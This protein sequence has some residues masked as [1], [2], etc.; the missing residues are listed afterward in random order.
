MTIQSAKVA[1]RLSLLLDR[2]G[3]GNIE[4]GT[5]ISEAA[6]DGM[7]MLEWDEDVFSRMTPRAQARATAI[8]ETPVAQ[9]LEQL[10][11]RLVE[12][13]GKIENV[14][15]LAKLS[16]TIAALLA[17]FEGLMTALIFTGVGVVV[18]GVPFLVLLALR[19]HTR[20]QIAA[21]HDEAAALSREARR[22]VEQTF[23][24][25]AIG[26][27]PSPPSPRGRPGVMTFA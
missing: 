12:R 2:N 5:E 25:R 11:E 18:L 15:D 7:R 20:S 26:Q 23:A 17:I 27:V 10:G 9:R 22:L 4:V 19:A 1:A 6:L 3:D 24:L 16:A 14:I 8:T 13:E 21:A